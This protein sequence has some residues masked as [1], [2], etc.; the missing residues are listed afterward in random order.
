MS[1]EEVNKVFGETVEVELQDINDADGKL[2][3][4][5]GHVEKVA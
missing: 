3:A 4:T 2:A 1:L 5:F